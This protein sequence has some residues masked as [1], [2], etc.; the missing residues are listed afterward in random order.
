MAIY[1]FLACVVV[2]VGVSLMT[3]A[4]SESQIKGLTFGTLTTEQKTAAKNSYAVWDVIASVV[5]VIV[6]I[7]ILFYFQG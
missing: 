2:C 6:I 7:C 4:P 1:M 3:P 5:L